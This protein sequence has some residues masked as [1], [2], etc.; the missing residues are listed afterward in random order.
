MSLLTAINRVCAVVGVHIKQSIFASLTTD[1][2][3]TEL[4]E[5]ANEIAQR[6]ARE[7]HD[8]TALE[9]TATFNGDGVT[10]AF[11]LPSNFYRMLKNANVWRSTNTFTPMRFIL[12]HDEWQQR[13]AQNYYD[14]Y[15][16]WT[17]AP[18]DVPGSGGQTTRALYVQ[19]ILGSGQTVRFNYLDKN[20][21]NLASG[22]VGET[23]TSDAD[24]FRL[25]ERLLVLNMIAEW[26]MRKGS[27]YA[28]DL[29]TYNDALAHAMGAD[30]PAPV[31]IDRLP[32]SA[33]ARISGPWPTNW[34][35]QP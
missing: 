26:K 3:V 15:G 35:P 10:A 22:G 29:G 8:W 5:L 33:D 32:I 28:E 2:T 23:F 12:S 14:G 1:R 19:P 13:R 20:P 27:P 31:I 24:T 34:G 30:R 11:P 21:I 25:D 9:R 17:L 18:M 6:I 4:L 16:E 7:T